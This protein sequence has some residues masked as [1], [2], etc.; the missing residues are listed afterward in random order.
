[1]FS[2][3]T[4]TI[5]QDTNIYLVGTTYSSNSTTITL[6][7]YIRPDDVIVIMSYSDFESGPSVPTGYTEGQ[8]GSANDVG[9]MWSYKVMTNPVD[10]T[11]SGLSQ[12]SYIGHIAM[13]FRNVDT[14]NVLDVAS[15]T[16][17]TGSGLPNPPSITTL[18]KSCVV[19]LGYL[20]NSILTDIGA[21]SGYSLAGSGTAGVPGTGGTGMAC[22][23][24]GDAGIY[25]PDAFTSASGGSG[26][27]STTLALRQK[28]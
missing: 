19:G 14:S 11:A 15:P 9:Y 4:K 2:L 13:A 26:W 21:P 3:A 20:E 24:L 28:Q 17:S 12:Q 25:N 5:L 23:L 18:N 16:R 10:T 1:M 7:S 8:R 6:P 22:Y 27:V